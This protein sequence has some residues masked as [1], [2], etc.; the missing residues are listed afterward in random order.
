MP[1]T[2]KSNLTINLINT[3]IAV[4]G[5]LKLYWY[6]IFIGIFF[7]LGSVGRFKNMQCRDC[8]A[9]FSKAE[10]LAE[11]TEKEHNK[12]L[13]SYGMVPVKRGRGRPPKHSYVNVGYYPAQDL[14]HIRPPAKR[15][16]TFYSSDEEDGKHLF[17]FIYWPV[18]KPK[19]FE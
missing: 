5:I 10:L 16:R 11:H 15:E 18:I 2:K 12:K 4:M 6:L 19:K 1:E 9:T 7:F 17:F 3:D 13:E 14:T 8:K